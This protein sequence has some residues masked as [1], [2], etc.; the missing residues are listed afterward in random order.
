MGNVSEIASSANVAGAGTT[1][2]KTEFEVKISVRSPTEKLRPGMTASADIV[3]DTR[4][5]AV[6]VAIQ[7]VTVRTLKQLEEGDENAEENFS[8]DADGF[9]E[10]VFIIEEGKAF[11][12]QVTTGIQSDELI[13]ITDG[14]AEGDE[15]ISG[16]YRAISRDLVHGDAVTV[17]NEEDTEEEA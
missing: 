4:A 12:R 14:L 5:D 1:E 15:V 17:N 16:S 6:S 2:Q 3:T 8:A 11:A 7:S 10:L 9:V 13:E